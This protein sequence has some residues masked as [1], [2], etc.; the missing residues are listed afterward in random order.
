MSVQNT[1]AWCPQMVGEDAE[2][3]GTALT[4]GCELPCGL[5]ESSPGPPQEQPVLLT[6]ES[7]VSP[8]QP[9]T[10]GSFLQYHLVLTSGWGKN[11][12]L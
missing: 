12:S 4:D 9:L 6:A 5:W 8:T 1:H 3:P 10:D 2:S 11:M 7:S